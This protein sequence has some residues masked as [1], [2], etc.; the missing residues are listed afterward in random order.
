MVIIRCKKG[1]FVSPRPIGSIICRKT[2]KE[3]RNYI[4]IKEE[5]EDGLFNYQLYARYLME[6]K[7]N[8][9]LNSKEIVH[10]KNKITTDDREENLELKTNGE[11][12][13]HHKK[14]IKPIKAIEESRKYYKKRREKYIVDIIGLYQKGWSIRKIT[15]H[16]PFHRDTIT[17]IIK[18][19]K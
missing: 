19:E 11:H 15:K 14:G 4:K 6:K 3:Y 5:T 13:S 12:T 9:E 2:G 1:R 16:I 10:H 7:L 18:E 8:R 17:K